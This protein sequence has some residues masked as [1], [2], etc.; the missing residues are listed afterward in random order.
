[1]SLEA[2]YTSAGAD[3]YA[4]KVRTRQ[5]AG[6]GQLFGV[7]YMD[8]EQR[9]SQLGLLNPLSPLRVDQFQTEFIRNVPGSFVVGGGQPPIAPLGLKL[10]RWTERATKLAFEANGGQGPVQL[11]QGFYHTPVYRPTFKGKQVHQYTPV[12]GQ[13]FSDKNSSVRQRITGAPAGPI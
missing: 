10:S 12:D 8:G 4:G 9:R 2:L 6:S 13:K 5:A 3:T 1:M 11:R 7:N